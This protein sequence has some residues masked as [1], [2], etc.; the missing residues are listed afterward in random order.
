MIFFVSFVVVG[1]LVLLQL[2]MAIIGASFVAAREGI[3][4][5]YRAKPLRMRKKVAGTDEHY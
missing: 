3:Y 5:D 1:N 4:G 2:L